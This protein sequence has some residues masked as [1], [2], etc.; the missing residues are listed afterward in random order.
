M[1][2]I[3]ELE[4]RL[5]AALDRIGAGLDG[6][7]RVAAEDDDTGTP[8]AAADPAELEALRRELEAER[9]VTAQLEE[10][11]RAVRSAQDDRVAELE[12]AL[13][14]SE[15]RV[16]PLQEDRQRLKQVNKQLRNSNVALR[17]ANAAG[18]A[19]AELI[20]HALEAELAGLRAAQQSDS[21]ELDAII[22]DLAPLV[23]T[24]EGQ[25]A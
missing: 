6:L 13:A 3:T 4:G 5:A 15:A 12:A 9:E 19:D 7:A 23:K 1:N 8:E 20:N 11:V 18:L 25:D 22:T 14:A 24:A 17:K 10:R 16:A 2:D 21:E